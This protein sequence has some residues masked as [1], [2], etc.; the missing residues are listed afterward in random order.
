MSFLLPDQ[1][2]RELLITRTFKKN[3]NFHSALVRF[4]LLLY[5]LFFS[6]IPEINAKYRQ[7]SEMID[8]LISN[9][10]NSQT[11]R[12]FEYYG[13]YCLSTFKFNSKLSSSTNNNNDASDQGLPMDEID[14]ACRRHHECISCADKD[15]SDR[16]SFDLECNPSRIGYSYVK[17]ID[18]N[19]PDNLFYRQI[20]CEDSTTNST[21]ELKMSCKRQICECDKK[22]AEDLRE[23]YVDQNNNENNNN[24]NKNTYGETL[25]AYNG[26]DYQ[27]KC[28]WNS[29]PNY[30]A[31][32]EKCCGKRPGIRWKYHD[33]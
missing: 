24:N 20:R 31:S 32:E 23:L 17:L 21:T 16:R 22:L 13:C 3:M 9:K 11:F 25:L 1:S 19:D 10:I 15:H 30:V 18:Q 7:L 2:Y 33:D 28:H 27:E 5:L 26:F 8:H 14:G 6:Q 4:A 12:K 29:D